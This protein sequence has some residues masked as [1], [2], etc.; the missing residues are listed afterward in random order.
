MQGVEKHVSPPDFHNVRLRVFKVASGRDYHDGDKNM[1]VIVN[2]RMSPKQ[3][4]ELLE[5]LQE[6]VANYKE[7]SGPIRFTLEGEFS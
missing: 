7:G 1:Q 6:Q 2:A 3:A 5:L 4:G